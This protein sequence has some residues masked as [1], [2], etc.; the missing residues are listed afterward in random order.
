MSHIIRIDS[1]KALIYCQ[2]SAQSLREECRQDDPVPANDSKEFV[3]LI[4]PA[5]SKVSPAHSR[6]FTFPS[7]SNIRGCHYQRIKARGTSTFPTKLTERGATEAMSRDCCRDGRPSEVWA[8]V[9]RSCRHAFKTCGE[10]TGVQ[11][12]GAWCTFTRL[13]DPTKDS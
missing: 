8:S 5:H 6:T 10:S 13:L 7:F 12:F 3:H 4:G 2:E 11:A 9:R 1:H